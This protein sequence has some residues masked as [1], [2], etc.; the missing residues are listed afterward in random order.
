MR[1]S[2]A[3]SARITIV[4]LCL[5]LL[6]LG[7]VGLSVGSA[8]WQS[9]WAVPTSAGLGQIMWEIRAPR[10]LGAMLVGALLGLGGAVAQGLFRNPLAEPYLLGSSSGAALGMALMLSFGMPDA[11]V[12]T[13]GGR[14]SLTGA[15]FIGAVGGVSLSLMLARGAAHTMRL[16]LGGVVVGVVLG[17]LTQLLMVWSASA[18]RIMQ[19]FMLGHTALLGWQACGLMAAVLCLTLPVAMALA[20]VLDALSLGEDA[21]RT[22]GIPLGLTR[23]VLVAVLALSTGAAVAQAGLV[24][25]VGL[26]APHLV[27]ARAG[28]RHG[29]LLFLSTLMGAVLLVAADIL[30]RLVLA[31]QELPVG[32]LTAVLGGTYLLWLLHRRRT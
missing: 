19:A 27:R 9:P 20:R 21:A 14:M 17:A 5:A 18:W 3:L 12:A 16:L 22:L 30:S 7:G 29:I 32:V 11:L 23:A 28:A 10:T 13:T 1:S 4:A 26:V 25:F 2:S 6:L 15:A 31:P 8:G 24:A